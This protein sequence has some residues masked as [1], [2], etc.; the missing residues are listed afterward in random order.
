MFTRIINYLKALLGFKMDQWEDPEVLLAQAQQEMQA[1]HAKNR[2]RAVSASTNKNQLQAEVDKTQRLISNL[3]AK[4][5]MALK[6]GDR[7]LARQLLVEKGTYETSLASLTESLNNALAIV[8]Q[9]KTAMKHEEDRIRQKAAE[10][11]AMKAQWKQSQIEIS[12]NKALEGM[13]TDESD[14]AFARA[15]ERI[16]KANS[17]SHART[18]LAA[19]S[20]NSK[21]AALD[22]ATA[23]AAADDELARLEQSMGLV[24]PTTA[25]AEK[26]ELGGSIEGQLDQLEQK[27]QVRG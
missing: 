17:E 2:E 26:L 11:L 3:Q 5:E 19:G 13:T 18:E 6:N 23:N 1:S 15:Q 9:V 20:L 10:A 22:N 25:R 7:D 8:E 12:L 16:Q 27:I 14:G 4:A 21:M 24:S